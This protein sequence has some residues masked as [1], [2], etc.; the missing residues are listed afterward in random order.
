MVG[1][2]T[3]AYNSAS[4]LLTTETISG[5]LY[6]KT[7]IHDY[8]DGSG[9]LSPVGRVPYRFRHAARVSDHL[10][11]RCLRSDRADH[12]AR[13]GFFAVP[14]PTYVGTFSVPMEKRI[15]S[16]PRV[17]ANVIPRGG[18]SSQETRHS[19]APVTRTLH[20]SGWIFP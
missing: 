19:V 7:V 5:G 8:Q 13:P 2:R 17:Y 14:I 10:R 16:P 3:F 6:N 4:L 1:T 18:G 20:S 11:L 12:R 9:E 15:L